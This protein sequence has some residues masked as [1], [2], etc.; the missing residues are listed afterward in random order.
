MSP[1][2]GQATGS[3]GID[4]KAIEP[5]PRPEKTETRAG[6]GKET[7]SA[8]LPTV[9]QLLELLVHD[10]ME[11]VPQSSLPH[12]TASIGAMARYGGLGALL[13]PAGPKPR[14][15]S[16]DVP[17]RALGAPKRVPGVKGVS[18][19]SLPTRTT[20]P[21]TAA[22]AA[23]SR[24]DFLALLGTAAAWA[25]AGRAKRRVV[26]LLN[27]AKVPGIER[28]VASGPVTTE[29]GERQG[30]VMLPC[31][32]STARVLSIKTGCGSPRIFEWAEDGCFL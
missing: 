9:F 31:L 8:A 28:C 20:R 21:R 11:N 12:L 32:P 6:E 19:P 3:V 16:L 14:A 30:L 18:A 17:S 29:D 4:V 15:M 27:N 7:A 22:P 2:S 26:K 23:V 13:D 10:F 24:S 25:V 5:S 1:S